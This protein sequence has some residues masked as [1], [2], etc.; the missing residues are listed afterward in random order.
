[1]ISVFL[2]FAAP[3][4]MSCFV[5]LS[6]QQTFVMNKS[7]KD[8]FCTNICDSWA[9]LKLLIENPSFLFFNNPSISAAIRLVGEDN[10]EDCWIKKK[11]S[12][13]IQEQFLVNIGLFIV[14]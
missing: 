7:G 12:L 8:I 2:S 10:N 3:L 5:F 1:M 9:L 14:E 4:A 11:N 6:V 13:K